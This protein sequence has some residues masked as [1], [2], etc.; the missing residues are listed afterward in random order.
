MTPRRTTDQAAETRAALLGAGREL[1]GSCGFSA[2]KASDIAER[3]GVTRGALLHHFGDKE[4][5]FASVLEEVETESAARVLEVAIAGSDPLEWLRRGFDAFLVECVKPEITRIMLIDGPSVLGWETWHEIDAR[6]GY[7]PLLDVLEAAV[8][9]GLVQSDDP[10]SLAY[11]L[12]GALTEAGTVIA[13]ADDPEA[14]R[15]RMA[16]ALRRLV[17]GL[18]PGGS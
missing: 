16:E 7:R 5:L 15:V 6:Y 9:A 2:T 13:H 11:L 12:L 3:A 14:T 8:E 4:G 1:F 10:G 17:D 18:V